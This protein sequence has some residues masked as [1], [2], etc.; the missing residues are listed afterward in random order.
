MS[1]M[2]AGDF[3]TADPRSQLLAA[4]VYE[5]LGIETGND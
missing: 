4:A 5:A 1:Q 3:G 2:W